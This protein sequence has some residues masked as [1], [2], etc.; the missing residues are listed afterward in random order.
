[1][2]VSESESKIIRLLFEPVPNIKRQMQISNCLLE[3][4][5]SYIAFLC[6]TTTLQYLQY[7]PCG[8]STCTMENLILCM[9]IWVLK[10]CGVSTCGISLAHC[11][12]NPVI[13]CFNLHHFRITSIVC[14]P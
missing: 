3:L 1:M 8:K 5:V 14:R 13:V 7:P 12:G 2:S 11:C 9:E 10:G 6:Y 4:A